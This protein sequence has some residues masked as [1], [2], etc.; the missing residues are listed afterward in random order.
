MHIVVAIRI[1]GISKREISKR[2]GNV[3]FVRKTGSKNNYYVARGSRQIRRKRGVQYFR[4]NKWQKRL[5]R[6]EFDRVNARFRPE[7]KIRAFCFFFFW[8]FRFRYNRTLVL[9][10]TRQNVRT[11][12]YKRS[13]F[14]KFPYLFDT[15]VVDVR[16]RA[17]A[18]Y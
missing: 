7:T 5:A 8:N 12:K 17:P 13:N 3:R 18:T 16:I 6:F 11:T 1:E 9:C 2:N 15:T 4:G 10:P 14:D